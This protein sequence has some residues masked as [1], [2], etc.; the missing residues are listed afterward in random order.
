VLR[1]IGLDTTGR[2]RF[3]AGG[4]QRLV[5]DIQP[6]FWLNPKNGVSYITSRRRRHN[7]RWTRWGDL[8]S[9]PITA[10]APPNPSANFSIA[11][12]CRH[13]WADNRFRSSA[14]LALFTR[15]EELATVTHYDIQPV[16]DIY[17][18]IDNTDLRSVA[19]KIRVILNKHQKELPRGSHMVIRGQVAD[20]AVVIHRAGEQ[21]CSS[22]SFSSIC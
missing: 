7:I 16:I 1:D 22:P 21:A 19:D 13:R 14:N 5:P 4:A 18:N 9:V 20:D 12:I 10:S 2:G 15:G 17:G 6:T 8:Q 3:P 11:H